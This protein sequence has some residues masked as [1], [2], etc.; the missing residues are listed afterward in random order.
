MTEKSLQKAFAQHG[1]IKYGKEGDNF[2]PALH[3][4]LFAM[5]D[6]TKTSGMFHMF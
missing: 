2:D 5:P 6:E 3:D 4:A 1:V